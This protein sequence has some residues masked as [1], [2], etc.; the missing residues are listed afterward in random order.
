MFKSISINY[1]EW[2]LKIERDFVPGFNLIE[3][4]NGYGKTTVLN[5][6]LSLWSKK[7][8]GLRSLPTGTAKLVTD[9][10][11]YMLTKG[12]WVGLEGEQNPLVKYILPGEFF[13]MS[14]PDQRSTIVKLLDI[15]YEAYMKSKVPEWTD[16]LEKETKTRLKE[17]VGKESVI[18][19][20]IVR[21]KAIV[22]KFEMNPVKLEDTS[23]NIENVYAVSL[24]KHNDNRFNILSENQKLFSLRQQKDYQIQQLK[25][26]QQKLREEYAS[27]NLSI[28]S[29]CGQDV[30]PTDRR[31]QIN[32]EGKEIQ[33]EIDKLFQ[34]LASI[35]EEKD[36]P[37]PWDDRTLQ[38]KA[39]Y[40]KLKLIVP[41]AEQ[42]AVVAEY[43][44]AKKELA[45]KQDM[46]KKLGELKDKEVLAMITQAKT[47]FTKELEEKVKVFG[48]DI[49]LF[50]E[51]ANGD[52][53]ESFQIS[54][55]GKPY[56]ELSGGHRLLIQLKMALAFV[57]KLGLDFIILDEAGTISQKNLDV[58]LKECEGLQ[59]IMA[60]ATPFKK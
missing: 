32:K 52:T 18:L 3:E 24:R 49:Q 51:Q 34:E 39:D 27:P 17:N 19:D 22:I 40:L 46:L 42:H 41:S 1:P 14:T 16:K 8:P 23:Q 44:M 10:T 54:L 43:E 53:V 35:P 6:I 58:I 37:E 31:A 36:V 30:D 25:A 7:Y 13:N 48:L 28:C 4:P 60:R 26:K 59:V 50:K 5:T 15:N 11:T 9:S 38:E 45:S 56:A 21:F 57:R 2:G 33:S 47:D 20:D 55:D 12:V 29:L